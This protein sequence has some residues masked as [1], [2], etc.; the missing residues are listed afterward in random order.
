MTGHLAASIEQSTGL[1][2][3]RVDVQLQDGSTQRPTPP[4]ASGGSSD[5]PSPAEVAA[6][7]EAEQS[8]AAV[9]VDADD[10]EELLRTELGAQRLEDDDA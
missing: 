6:V 2:R 3:I 10:V 1:E 9:D 4:P 8:D 5:A 7:S